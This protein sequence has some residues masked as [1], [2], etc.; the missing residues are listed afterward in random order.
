MLLNSSTNIL[1]P[2]EIKYGITLAYMTSS[3]Y[4]H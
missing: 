1:I 3:L 4:M 2:V